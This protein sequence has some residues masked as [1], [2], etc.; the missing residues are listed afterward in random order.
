MNYRDLMEDSFIHPSEEE[1]EGN[2]QCLRCRGID[3]LALLK[4]EGVTVLICTLCG[5]TMPFK[6]PDDD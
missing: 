6:E 5:A 1:L 3:T 2:F 4:Q